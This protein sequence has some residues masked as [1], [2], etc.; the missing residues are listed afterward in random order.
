M[1]LNLLR[2]Y[3]RNFLLENNPAAAKQLISPD[4]VSSG[5]G[6]KESKD[7]EEDKKDE[8]LEINEF[9]GVG[10]VAGF[11]APLGMG[12]E[13]MQGYKKRKKVKYF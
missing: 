11:S 6:D 12:S 1:S 9:S 7:D 3:I 10:A 2:S 5:G 13:D 4:S 8:D